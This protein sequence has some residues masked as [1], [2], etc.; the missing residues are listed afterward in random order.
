MPRA[1]KHHDHPMGEEV[2]S[3]ALH[4]SRRLPLMV[5]A[6]VAP[7]C[8]TEQ[9]SKAPTQPAPNGPLVAA[10]E[11]LRNPPDLAASPNVLRHWRDDVDRLPQ[12]GTGHP[13]L[14][15][16]ICVHATSPSGWRM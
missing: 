7:Q 2:A 16:G 4:A 10:R 15:G 5:V 13:R 12:L 8:A 14:G 6:R 3:S 1:V 9:A 11:L